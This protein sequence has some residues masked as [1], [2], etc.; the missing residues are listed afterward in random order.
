MKMFLCRFLAGCAF[1]ALGSTSTFAVTGW[2]DDYEKAL[3]QAKAE[4][5]MV[6][7]D[8][9]GSDWCG[10]CIKLDKEVFSE[11][12]FKSYAKDNLVLVAVDF[13]QRHKL[14]KEKQEQNDALQAQY[15]VRGYPTIIVLNPEGKPVG[16][17]GYQPGGPKAFIAKLDELKGK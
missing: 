11:T 13:P 10:W 9:T 4:K 7:L 1:L 6:L 3:A 16:K 12:E 15:G 17:L 5:K 2:G 14:P 8:L